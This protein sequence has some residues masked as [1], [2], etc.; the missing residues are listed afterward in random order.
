MLEFS[1]EYVSVFSFTVGICDILIHG[2]T[3][4]IHCIV[5]SA[6]S[7]N[8]TFSLSH[9]FIY[10]DLFIYKCDFILVNVMTVIFKS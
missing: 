1:T 3:I 9:G 5:L 2:L 6:L 8:T 10:V 7:D 4:S